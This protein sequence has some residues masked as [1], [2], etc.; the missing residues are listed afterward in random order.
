MET[1]GEDGSVRPSGGRLAAFDIPS[2]PGI[3]VDS[4]GYAGYQTSPSFD[5]LLAKLIVHAGNPSFAAAVQKTQRALSEFKIEGVSTNAGF[6]QA[7]LAP[8]GG[9]DFGSGGR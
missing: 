1:M 7:I 2:G 4:F 6:L 3:R 9:N 8:R 5:S